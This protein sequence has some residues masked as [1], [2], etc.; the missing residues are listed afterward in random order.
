MRPGSWVQVPPL[1]L[2]NVLSSNLNIITFIN[3]H[4]NVHLSQLVERK[5]FI[6]VFKS[7]SG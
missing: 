5:T 1:L 3:I 7:H 2:D 6:R 4:T